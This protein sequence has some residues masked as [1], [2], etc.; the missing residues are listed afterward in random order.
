M[1]LAICSSSYIAGA[2]YVCMS[3]GVAGDSGPA[4]HPRVNLIYK[5]FWWL[6]L[7]GPAL[8]HEFSAGRG[9]NS[10]MCTCCNSAVLLPIDVSSC[11]REA[12]VERVA[13]QLF[14]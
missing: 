14:Q 1:C 11:F 12:T 3:S 4:V 10:Q 8:R 13:I 2:M 9:G 6:W 7:S 5:C